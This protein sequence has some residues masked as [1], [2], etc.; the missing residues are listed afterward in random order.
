MYIYPLE[1]EMMSV[2]HID[3][4]NP[5]WLACV[6]RSLL[7]SL[8]VSTNKGRLPVPLPETQSLMCQTVNS[9][10]P[11]ITDINAYP[12]KNV[13]YRGGLRD[14]AVALRIIVLSDW[15]EMGRLGTPRET[16]DFYNSISAAWTSGL[17][18]NLG[19]KFGQMS[20]IYK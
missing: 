17:F 18:A 16:V 13:L 2:R 5:H 19:T 7:W 3:P 4:L 1:P 11:L 20:V 15:T 14:L 6:G 8:T 12:E 9:L 10:C